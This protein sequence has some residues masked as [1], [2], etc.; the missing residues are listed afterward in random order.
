MRTEAMQYHAT[1]LTGQADNG[2]SW[3]MQHRSG[4][5]R[6]QQIKEDKI[7]TPEGRLFKITFV[8]EAVTPILKPRR[9]NGYK[10]Y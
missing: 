5:T 2:G 4:Q 8:T 1:F 9:A 3:T 10:C 6:Q 7:I